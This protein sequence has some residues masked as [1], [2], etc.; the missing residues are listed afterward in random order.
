MKI[1]YMYM[2]LLAIALLAGCTD[3]DTVLSTGM[4][5]SKDGTPIRY[6]S[7]G[8]GKTAIVFIHC[9]TCDHSFWNAQYQAFADKYKVVRLD[10]AGHGGSANRR[11]HTITKFADDVVAVANALRLQRM[12]LVGQSMGGPVSVAAEQQ[13]GER[14]IAVV[15]VDSFYTPFVFPEDEQGIRE[16]VQP[17]EHDLQSAREAMMRSMFA[18][19]ARTELLD[20]VSRPVPEASHD[21]AVQTIYEIFRW[22]AHQRAAALAALGDKLRNINGDPQANG[23][24]LHDSVVL[25]AGAGHFVQMEKPQEFNQALQQIITDM[26]K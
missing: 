7:K 9:W 18:P 24:P 15:G 11:Q 13:L 16:F 26:D 20:K 12:V 5:A 1:H 8:E 25:I 6:Q 14:V 19:G 21:M 4:T 22:S 3:K 23:K 17:F 2:L 10:L